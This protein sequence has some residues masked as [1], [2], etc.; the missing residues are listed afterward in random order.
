SG[1]VGQTLQARLDIEALRGELRDLPAAASGTLTL[2]GEQ[3]DIADL[4]LALGTASLTAAGRVDDQWQLRLAARAPELAALLP[5]TR[6]ALQLAAALSG[7]RAT[8]RIELAAELAELR[9]QELQAA[10]L[11]LRGSLDLAP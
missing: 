5:D 2:D 11:A 7:P 6:G 8:P 1:R 3:L 4:Q 9:R 10:R